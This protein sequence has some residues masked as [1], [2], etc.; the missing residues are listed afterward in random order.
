[1]KAAIVHEFGKPLSIEEIPTPEPGEGQVLVRIEASGLCHTDIHAAHGDWPVK[2]KL[3]LIPGHEGVGIVEA[4]G[5]GANSGIQEGDRVAIPWLGYACGHCRHCNDGWETLCESQ[6]NTGYFLHGAYAV[7]ACAFSRHVVMVPDGFDPGAAAPLTCAGVTT[8]KAVKV[9]GVRP[10]QLCAV[11][12]IGGLGHMALQY[13]KIQGATVVAVDLHD[14]KLATARELGADYV[15]NAREQ[16]AVKAIKDLGG[17]DAA[18]ATA[19]SPKAFEQAYSSLARGGTLVFVG[20]PADNHV[21]LPIFE[22]V[23]NGITIKG[24]IVG[25]HHDLEA[26]FRLH[27]LGRTRVLYETRPLEDV[28]EAFAEVEQAS[29]NAPRVVLQP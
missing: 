8:Y 23:L 6:S 9:S 4:I 26:V 12:G 16:D 7:Y 2:P 14:D 18:I 10:A 3:P 20:L 27:G 5:P 17:A 25:T 29:T 24:S 19:V 15:V 1:M 22:T 11:F 13:A 21:Q 28:N